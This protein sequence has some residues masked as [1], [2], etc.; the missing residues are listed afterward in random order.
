ML[1]VDTHAHLSFPEFDKDRPEIIKRALAAGIKQI[2]SIGTNIEDCKNT[3]A[4]AKEYEFIFAAVGIHP[5]ETK[6]IS[7]ETYFQLQ[8]LAADSRVVAIGEIGL[9]FYRNLSPP[10]VQIH[11]FREQLR[12]ARDF[13]LPVIIHDRNAHNEIIKILQEEK[14]ETIGGVIHCFSGDQKMAQK[15]MDMGF[16]IS[17]PGTVTYKKSDEYRELVRN[18]PLERI[19]LETDCPFLAPHPFRGKRNEPAYLIY[20]VEIVAQIKGIKKEEL[21]TLTTIN[22]KKLFNF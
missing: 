21:A 6:T 10:E 22:A 12:L 11:H 2:V 16:Y 1:V 15:C 4:L 17:I 13:S 20:T 19:L 18:L 14:A 7:E 5:H 9:D 3:L 8:N